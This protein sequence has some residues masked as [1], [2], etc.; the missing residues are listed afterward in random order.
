MPLFKSVLL[1]CNL[2]PLHHT[3][4]HSLCILMEMYRLP[5]TSN[6][7]RPGRGF[8]FEFAI[9]SFWNESRPYFVFRSKS[10]FFINSTNVWSGLLEAMVFPCDEL[11]WEPGLTSCVTNVTAYTGVHCSAAAVL[12]LW[13][14][15]LHLVSKSRRTMEQILR[16]GNLGSSK[17]VTLP[18]PSGQ[19]LG[20]VI[21]CPP[22]PWAPSSQPAPWDHCHLQSYFSVQSRPSCF[23]YPL[24]PVGLDMVSSCHILNQ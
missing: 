9:N 14:L 5:Y 17:C 1:K 24:F 13:H 4:W 19:V 11:S 20:H 15:N 2:H 7:P 21:L 10:S 22:A 8:T 18:N 12:T 6:T 3:C 23:C 16:P